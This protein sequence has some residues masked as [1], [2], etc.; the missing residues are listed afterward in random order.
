MAER[1]PEAAA[2]QLQR[3]CEAKGAAVMGFSAY[4][5]YKLLPINYSSMRQAD[6]L[7]VARGGRESGHAPLPVCLRDVCDRYASRTVRG[8]PLVDWKWS[9]HT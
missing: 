2:D 1:A 8:E 4:I 3:P 5:A 9:I 6:F 7:G